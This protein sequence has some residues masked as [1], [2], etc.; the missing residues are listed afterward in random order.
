MTRRRHIAAP[1]AR[2][3]VLLGAL[4]LCAGGCGSHAQTSLDPK[5]AEAYVDAEAHALCLVQSK[6]FP[7]QA[8]LHTAFVRAERSG[9]LSSDELA[10][11]RAAALQDVALRRRISDRVAERCGRR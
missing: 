4:V 8:A 3:L 2:T 1:A 11:A 7:T 9:D 10:D 5:V 6:A